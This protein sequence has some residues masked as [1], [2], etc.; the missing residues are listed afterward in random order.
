MSCTGSGAIVATLTVLIIV[1]Q[2]WKLEKGPQKKLALTLATVLFSQVSLG[3]A[4][5]GFTYRY[6]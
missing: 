6:R 1:Y 5:Y 2:L 4:M 3:S